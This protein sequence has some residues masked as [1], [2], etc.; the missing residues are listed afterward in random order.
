MPRNELLIYWAES[1]LPLSR[2]ERER[3]EFEAEVASVQEYE[4]L[5]QLEGRTVVIVR[6]KNPAEEN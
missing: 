4:V 3:L 6:A 5:L 2:E 1:G